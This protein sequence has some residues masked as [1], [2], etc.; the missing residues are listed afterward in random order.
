MGLEGQKIGRESLMRR[1]LY[2]PCSMRILRVVGEDIVVEVETEA[3]IVRMVC[4]LVEARW[5]RDQ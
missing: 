4:K 5:K 2:V 1:Q 3:D